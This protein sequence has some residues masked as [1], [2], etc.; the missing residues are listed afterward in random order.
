MRQAQR[1]RAQPTTHGKMGMGER[2]N[3]A[4]RSRANT[5]PEPKDKMAYILDK[6]YDYNYHNA[7][8]AIYSWPRHATEAL[9]TSELQVLPFS[10][11][12]PPKKGPRRL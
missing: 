9:T 1:G 6:Q 11:K 3:H 8:P 5:Y 12:R 7:L 10:T 4:V 2:A